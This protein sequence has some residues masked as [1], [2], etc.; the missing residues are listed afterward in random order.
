[1]IDVGGEGSVV[2]VGPGGRGHCRA[3]FGV[4]GLEV[5]QALRSKRLAIEVALERF[6][7][8]QWWH[9]EYDVGKLERLGHEDRQGNDDDED[10]DDKSETRNSAQV[11]APPS[12]PASSMGEVISSPDICRKAGVGINPH[13]DPTVYVHGGLKFANSGRPA[14]ALSEQVV[15]EIPGGGVS[16]RWWTPTA[17]HL[18]EP[19]HQCRSQTIH[20]SGVPKSHGEGVDVSDSDT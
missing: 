6:R 20:T 17:R 8:G 11:L 12:M 14:E 4:I 2:E 16:A 13:A 10:D 3:E 7:M 15:T 5:E 9:D 18:C 1:M 19:K